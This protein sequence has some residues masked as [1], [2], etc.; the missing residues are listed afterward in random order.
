MPNCCG[1]GNV[2]NCSIQ[3]GAGVA[4]SGAG[5]SAAPYIISAAGGGSGSV[6]SLATKTG[7]YTMLVT[8]G[9]IIANGTSITITLPSAAAAGSSGREYIVKNINASSLTVASASGNID[10]VATQTLSQYM[11]MSF[12]SNGTV[13]WV[14]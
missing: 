14:V 6:L 13:W 4:V 10:G 9:V 2:C 7:N 12:V 1:A 8:D 11:A 5:T 3:A